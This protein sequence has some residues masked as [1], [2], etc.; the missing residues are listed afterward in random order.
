MSSVLSARPNHLKPVFQQ[1]NLITPLNMDPLIYDSPD[2]Y[3]SSKLYEYGNK[4]LI[5]GTYDLLNSIPGS[6][7]T[8]Y[9]DPN[10][11]TIG[12]SPSR[13]LGS[14]HGI[15]SPNRWIDPLNCSN[16]ECSL[17]RHNKNY[18]N[19]TSIQGYQGVQQT[20]YSPPLISDPP[21]NNSGY[22][23][24]ENPIIAATDLIGD[25]NPIYPA[26]SVK[27]I[28]DLE[29]R[30]MIITYL[31][32]KEENVTYE[33]CV[34]LSVEKIA[35]LIQNMRKN[36][37]YLSNAQRINLLLGVGLTSEFQSPTP[38]EIDNAFV[39]WLYTY[40]GYIGGTYWKCCGE[41]WINIGTSNF[42][43]SP[44]DEN[45][46]YGIQ[47]FN[48]DYM[49]E[50]RFQQYSKPVLELQ[51]PLI[52]PK[53]RRFCSMARSNWDILMFNGCYY[54]EDIMHRKQLKLT[55]L[56]TDNLWQI[57]QTL[58]ILSEA[59]KAA[60]DRISSLEVLFTKLTCQLGIKF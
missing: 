17:L 44:F 48:I 21:N 57:K 13:W 24:P 42:E 12:L 26:L 49:I 22:T 36:S 27:S 23:V 59:Q 25:G 39:I 51:Y 50:R 8:I 52:L 55:R 37:I 6:S 47:S 7:S 31:L 1:P 32:Y 53:W 46:V 60:D 56:T 10:N 19:G 35:P 20:N 34:T 15:P 38:Q 16:G 4:P 14:T 3:R 33:Q 41:R 29:S 54:S 45:L 30:R 28:F 11:S 9:V 5:A 58:Q 40:I 43:F 18:Y 2:I